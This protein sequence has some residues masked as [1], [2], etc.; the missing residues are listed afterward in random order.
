MMK[1]TLKLTLLIVL[2][3]LLNACKKSGTNNSVEPPTKKLK[4][5]TQIIAVNGTTTTF[6]DLTYDDKNRLLTYNIRGGGLTK[7]AYNG[8]DLFSIEL[9]A[10]G[11]REIN[12][13]GYQD[14]K[15]ISA[16]VKKYYNNIL[17]TDI[18][19]NYLYEGGRVTEMHHDIYVDTYSYDNNNN[20]TKIYFSQISSA[21]VFTYDNKLS[22]FTNAA[23]KSVV[24]SDFDRYS[25][26]NV[27]SVTKGTQSGTTN[28][29]YNY[30]SDG[31][32]TGAVAVND[33][34]TYLNTKY[35]YTYTE[36]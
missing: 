3:V 8:N 23:T 30:D 32:P 4:Y 36:L 2:V 29:T 21:N 18:V 17:G 1:T 11:Y 9:T 5:L 12:E 24:L 16:H 33:A 34:Y 22:R 31:Y 7:Y 13:F 35:T 25:P 20:V 6:T 10:T 28:Y 15:M 14:G 26:N 19:Y 27:A